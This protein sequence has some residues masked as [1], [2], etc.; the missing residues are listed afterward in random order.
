MNYSLRLKTERWMGLYVYARTSTHTHAHTHGH[1]HAHTRAHKRAKSHVHARAHAYTRTHMHTL[2]HTHTDAYTYTQT[3]TCTHTH[4]Y[5]HTQLHVH[6]CAHTRTRSPH[7]RKQIFS[8]SD[9]FSSSTPHPPPLQQCFTHVLL[10][11]E[12][13]GS[14]GAAHSEIADAGGRFLID[15][16]RVGSVRTEGM[17]YQPLAVE[18]TASVV[19]VHTLSSLAICSHVTCCMSHVAAPI[20]CLQKMNWGVSITK[21]R[22]N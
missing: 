9:F 19:R 22:I 21:T 16:E 8:G 20:W 10:A 11:V 5:T 18:P 4:T 14:P 3:H 7:T 15:I 13:S 17:R 2:T 12:T 6:I 1:T